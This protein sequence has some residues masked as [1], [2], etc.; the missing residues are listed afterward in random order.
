MKKLF[1]KI[2]FIYCELFGVCKLC[3]GK[4]VA[5]DWNHHYCEDC[6]EDQEKII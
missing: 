3:G 4:V 6:N 2:K 1:R 5:W